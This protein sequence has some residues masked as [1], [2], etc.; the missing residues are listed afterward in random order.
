MEDVIAPLRTPAPPK[1][2]G[3]YALTWFRKADGAPCSK[4]EADKFEVHVF[5]AED[6]VIRRTYGDR[7]RA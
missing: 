1:S 4:D 5:D 7:T 3:A 6:R 2:G